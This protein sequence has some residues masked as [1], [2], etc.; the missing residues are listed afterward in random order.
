M[1]KLGDYGII[2]LNEM[3]SMYYHT[4]IDIFPEE[5]SLSVVKKSVRKYDKVHPLSDEELK[6]KGFQT[7]KEYTN[8][9]INF[10]WEKIIL[11]AVYR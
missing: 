4:G 9:R 6:K 7:M 11:P 3:F 8:A 2:S 10:I 1:S 5:P